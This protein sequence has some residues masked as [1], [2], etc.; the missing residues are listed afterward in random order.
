MQLPSEVVGAARAMREVDATGDAQG[1]AERRAVPIDLAMDPVLIA[2]VLREV[3]DRE[4]EG[5]QG[6]RQVV[7]GQDPDVPVRPRSPICES[8]IRL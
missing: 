4:R 8:R 2:G 1:E 7:R 5:E 3:A 6:R